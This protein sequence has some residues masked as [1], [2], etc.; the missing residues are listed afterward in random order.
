MPWSIFFNLHSFVVTNVLVTHS[1]N[2]SWSW[3]YGE[4]LGWVS[5]FKATN[6]V[7]NQAANSQVHIH[8]ILKGVTGVI[9]SN[10]GGEKLVSNLSKFLLFYEDI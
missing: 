1:F 5:L 10:K 2:F 6:E 8:Q 9:F 7:L 3:T 4:S